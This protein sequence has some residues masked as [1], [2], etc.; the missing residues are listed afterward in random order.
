MQRRLL[1][2]APRRMSRAGGG[3]QRAKGEGT[4]R[5]RDARGTGSGGQRGDTPRRSNDAGPGGARGRPGSLAEPRG[6]RKG[7]Q[8]DERT[9]RGAAAARSPSTE[10]S[11]GRSK[12]PAARS[13]GA[14][15]NAHLRDA[16]PGDARPDA[17]ESKGQRDDREA[18]RT[19][20]TGDRGARATGSHAEPGGRQEQGRGAGSG[21]FGVRVRGAG[22]KLSHEATRPL[23]AGHPWIFRDALTRPLD[24]SAGELITVADSDGYLLGSAMV[25]GDGAVALRMVSTDP[26]FRWTASTA[27]ERLALALAWRERQ[28]ASLPVESRRLVHGEADGFPG[29][30]VD[31]YRDRLV[32]YRYAACADGFLDVLL[33]ALAEQCSPS[34]IYVQHRTRGVTPDDRRPAAELRYG[35]PPAAT[36]L[37]IA[38]DEDGLKLWV[39]PSAPVSPG[40]FLDLREGRR[41]FE[42]LCAGKRV[43]NLF[44]FTGAFSLRAVRAGAASVL[45][46]DAAARSH[47]RCRQ[48]LAISGLDSEA[49]ET[50]CGDALKHLEKLRQHKREFDL[51]VVDPPPFS[52]VRGSVFSALDDWAALLKSIAP[53]VAPD[54]QVLAVCNAVRL[55]EDDFLA[56]VGTGAR[57]S[58]RVAR[59]VGERALPTDFPVLPGF[60]EGRYLKIK[61]LHLM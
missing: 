1:V 9:S 28:G 42:T 34:A 35:K 15:G 59:L 27:G 41:H 58:G 61:Q 47:A 7:G 39:D 44:S 49:C 46:V 40:L 52:N 56:A 37:E 21:S 20:V 26:E 53:V 2:Y 10:A 14:R 29:V 17:R 36:D 45:N 50:F 57:D 55:P 24:K 23:R 32:V 48:N 3:P 16:R 18:P 33:D 60:P 31:R 38:V 6:A 43:L 11:S 8:G 19:R 54:G 4:T 30:A 5:D 51:V 22:V 25:D 12:S 13:S